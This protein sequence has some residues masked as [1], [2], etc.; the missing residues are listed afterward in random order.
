MSELKNVRT[1]TL[2]ALLSAIGIIAGFFKIPISEIIE[3]RFSLL[4]IAV[5][6]SVFGPCIAAIVGIV[7]DLGGFLIKPTG[8]YFPGFTISGAVSGM[9]FGLCLYQ[10]RGTVPG[11]HRVLA[12]VII[13]SVIVNLLLNSLWLTLLYGKGG[14]VAV[15]SARIVKELIMIPINIIMIMAV[16][17]PISV[18]TRSQSACRQ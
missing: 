11:I 16:T 6:G 13:N 15:L 5:A 4:P 3:I 14:F 1:L 7:S 12:A 9:I 10:K 17:R 18:I 2:A 8:P